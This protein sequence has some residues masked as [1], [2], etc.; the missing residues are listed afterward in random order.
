MP[1][2]TRSTEPAVP[3]AI[4]TY[5]RR[6]RAPARS[7]S[8][9][10][11]A[12]I[13]PA[14]TSGRRRRGGGGIARAGGGRGS[15]RAQFLDRACHAPPPPTVAGPHT[16]GL[17]APDPAVAGEAAVAALGARGAPAGLPAI[18]AACR[19]KPAVRRRA[20]LALAPFNGAEVEEALHTALE[21]RDWQ[22]RQAAEDLLA[23]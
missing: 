21:D 16:P 20:V 7:S 5:G 2:T 13:V 14:A 17:R 11:M 15:F 18:L 8:T 6:I 19:D 23:E 1:L 10:T 3:G 4:S 12:A 9:A 22:V